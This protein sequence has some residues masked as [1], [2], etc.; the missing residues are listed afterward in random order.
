MGGSAGATGGASGAGGRGG[1][2]GSGGIGGAS[3]TGGAANG[4]GSVGGGGASGSGGVT[5]VDAGTDAGHD[6]IHC[7]TTFCR[8]V[9]EFCCI[10]MGGSAR[11][12]ASTNPNFCPD[13]AAKVR[14]DDHTDCPIATQICC[15]QEGGGTNGATATCRAPG[16][17][18]G[19]GRTEIL[20]DPEAPS[21]CGPGGG[22]NV[23]RTDN[24]SVI[25]GYPSC[26]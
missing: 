6:D 22:M 25:P 12:V 17:C 7:G 2:G 10:P 9:T 3:G 11:C 19:M 15:A 20:C 4:G 5:V 1:A 21:P 14:C 13:S 18:N 23:C 24:Q 16:N 8:A 26:H